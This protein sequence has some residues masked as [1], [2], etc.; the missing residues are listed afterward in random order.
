MARPPAPRAQPR[1]SASQLADYLVSPTPVGQIGIL[2][3]AKN[4]GP[5]RPMIIQYNHA[6]RAIAEC[7]RDRAGV[8]RIVARSVQELEER[9][10]NGTNGPLVRD[11]AQR[12]ID[13]IEAFQRSTNELDLWNAEYQAPRLPVQALNIRGVEIS[14]APDAIA[15]S[16]RR[17]EVRVGQVFI[18]CTI[19]TPG[20]AAQGRRSEAN[21][22]LATIAHLHTLHYLA[23]LGTPHAPTSVVV[24]VPRSTVVR[25][26][27]NSARRIANI[28]AA[29]G[30]IAAI[31]P[32]I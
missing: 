18:R 22:I 19:G 26:P 6:R 11:D 31:W 29:C 23:D 30:M 2:R 12:C 21:G 17:N 10:D 20:D 16:H 15:V 14:V 3:Q 9:R 32:N 25:G 13:V 8:N 1:L 5:N 27:V 4:P 7:L 28:E 24:D